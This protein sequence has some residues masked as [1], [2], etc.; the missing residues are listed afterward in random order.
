[1][2]KASLAATLLL[3]AAVAGWAAPAAR[4]LVRVG[5]TATTFDTGARAITSLGTWMTFLAT[6]CAPVNAAVG[7]AVTAPGASRLRYTMLVTLTLL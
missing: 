4:T 5:A 1:M 2:L 6:G 7:T 3:G